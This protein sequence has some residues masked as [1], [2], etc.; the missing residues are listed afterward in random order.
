MHQPAPT[1]RLTFLLLFLMLFAVQSALVGCGN[2]KT[3]IRGRVI[4]GTVGQAVVAAPGDE[5]FK[6]PG[7]PEMSVAVLAR[8]GS[9]ARGRGV[10]AEAVSDENG[11]FELIFPG[12]SFPRD[13]VEIRVSGD[14]TFTA[15][16]TT[17]MPTQG[18][19]LLCVVI[20]R[21]GYV[22]PEPNRQPQE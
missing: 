11:D 21:P 15:R 5:R 7:L 2:A 6:D 10:F 9:T 18:N 13:I 1:R 8:G 22:P 16:S 14:G 4:S 20:P 3:T 19:Q 17:Y 12:G